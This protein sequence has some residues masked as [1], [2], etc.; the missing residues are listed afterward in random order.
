M[1]QHTDT[2]HSLPMDLQSSMA[3]TDQRKEKKGKGR[4][5][6]ARQGRKGK[7]GK[8]ANIMPFGRLLLIAHQNAQT[9]AENTKDSLQKRQTRGVSRCVCEVQAALLNCMLV[10]SHQSTLEQAVLWEWLSALAVH[11]NDGKQL[12]IFFCYCFIRDNKKY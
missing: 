5:G 3:A 8:K 4:E 2:A 11:N 6:K 12:S 7:G 1:M 9:R 10:V